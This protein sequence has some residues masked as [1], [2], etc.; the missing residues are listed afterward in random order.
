MSKKTR[1]STEV[2]LTPEQ[3]AEA[4]WNFRDDE[5]AVFFAHLHR[6]A[7]SML[8]TQMSA[9]TARLADMDRAGG[10]DALAGFETIAMHSEALWRTAIDRA[11]A[12]AKREIAEQAA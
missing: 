4:F 7:G 11:C 9:L 8:C 6:I 1:I 2:K 12:K 10:R 3:V 5:Q